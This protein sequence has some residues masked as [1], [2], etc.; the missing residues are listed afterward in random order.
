MKV[1]IKDITGTITKISIDDNMLVKDMKYKIWVVTALDPKRQELLHNGNVLDN[2]KQIS[3]YKIK[4]E[5]IVNLLISNV[6]TA[7]YYNMKLNKSFD[8]DV[9]VDIKVKK[10]KCIVG[11]NHSVDTERIKIVYSGKQ[12]ENNDNLP[13]RKHLFVIY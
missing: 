4:G 13:D 11:K 3:T 9:P 8:I 5:D 2:D 1:F 6:I 12:L 10:F 7:T